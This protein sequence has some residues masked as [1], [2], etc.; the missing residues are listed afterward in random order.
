[1]R[2]SGRE[3]AAQQHLAGDEVI[4]GADEERLLSE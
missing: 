2:E 1:M 3:E 4:F